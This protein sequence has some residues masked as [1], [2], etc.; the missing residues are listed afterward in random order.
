[1]SILDRYADSVAKAIAAELRAEMA[2]QN[3]KQ[4]AVALALGV[5]QSTISQK[6]SG[7]APILVEEFVMW[8]EFLG[9]DPGAFL[10]DVLQDY[11]PLLTAAKQGDGEPEVIDGEEA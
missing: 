11:A 8:C 5:A 9:K 7:N 4:P 6:L 1:M 3:L 2:R 10:D